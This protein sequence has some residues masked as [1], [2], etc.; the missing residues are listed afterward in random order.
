MKWMKRG[1]IKEV[2]PKQKSG[3]RSVCIQIYLCSERSSS[4]KHNT[5]TCQIDPEIV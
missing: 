4:Q 2:D 1:E 3:H 5:S